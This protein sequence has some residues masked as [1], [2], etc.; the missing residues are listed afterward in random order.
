MAPTSA[1]VLIMRATS[2]NWSARL[3]P[4]GDTWYCTAD[5]PDMNTALPAMFI[6]V[7]VVVPLPVPQVGQLR[8]QVRSADPQP[9]A[10]RGRVLVH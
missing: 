2:F 6:Q 10:Q 8:Q 9:A 4:L 1:A 7:K 5:R 3:L